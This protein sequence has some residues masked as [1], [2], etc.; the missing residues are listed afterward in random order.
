MTEPIIFNWKPNRD[1]NQPIQKQ[2]TNF[3]LTQIRA[4]VL[5]PDTRL[6][7]QRDLAAQFGVNRST[8]SSVLAELRADG[9]VEG[10]HGGG[11]K[12]AS[13]VWG[14]LLH[15]A[16]T[17]TKLES[18]GSFI[19]NQPLIQAIN[20]LEFNPDLLRLGTGELDP[21]L[22]PTDMLSAAIT[23]ISQHPQMGYLPPLGLLELRQAIAKHFSALNIDADNVLITSGSLQG[24]HLIANGL[25]PDQA[26]M[27]IEDPSY[28]ASVNTFQSSGIQLK[29]TRMDSEGLMISELSKVKGDVLYTIP[30]N[31]NPT[32]ITMSLDRRKALLRYCSENQLPIIEDSAYQELSFGDSPK[33][34]KELDSHDAVL[35]IGTVS[36]S[37]LPGLRIGWVIAPKPIVNRLGDIKMQ[38]DYGASSLSQWLVTDLF[39]S[40]DYDSYVAS[41]R[42]ILKHRMKAA[43]A[44]LKAELSEIATWTEPTGGFYIWVQLPQQVSVLNVFQNA[45]AA[46][47]LINPGDVYSGHKTHALRVSFAYLNEDEF[48]VGLHKVAEIIKQE[49]D[50]VSY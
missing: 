10:N 40:G 18:N 5:A 6:P 35:Q 42:A 49:L 17:W 48:S 32:G 22:V 9:I 43:S 7:S 16:P 8:V 3:L 34:L 33:S 11:T 44:C 31:H 4:G 28:I 46:G 39:N 50:S 13:D 12:V 47:V 14:L 24:L 29:P 2:L 20:K 25:L 37:L 45:V 1:L 23:R 27:L 26:S 19:K 38:I 15:N 30:T 36:K 41:L 21:R